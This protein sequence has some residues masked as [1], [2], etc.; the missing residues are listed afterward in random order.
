LGAEEA[1]QA[2]FQILVDLLRAA[3]EAHGR[4]AVTVAIERTLRCLAN[5]GVVGEPQIVVRA[6]IHDFTTRADPH[7]RALRGRQNPLG[8]EQALGFQLLGLATQPLEDFT[9]HE[10]V[11]GTHEGGELCHRAESSSNSDV[12][13]SM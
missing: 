1:A 7:Y 3:D 11:L 6:Q 5:G 4:H 13:H 10:P 12:Q 2:R 8:L 9:L